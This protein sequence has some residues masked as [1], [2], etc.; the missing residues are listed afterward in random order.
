MNA[1]MLKLGAKTL[2]RK[3]GFFLKRHAPQILVGLGVGGFVGTAVATGTA[4][5]KAKDI[6][7]ERD[8]KLE[9]ATPQEARA[10]KRQ[11]AG[12]LAKTF[13]PPVTLGCASAALIF[14]GHGMMGRRAAAALTAAYGAQEKAHKLY[15]NVR[16]QLG[17]ETADRLSQGLPIDK[18]DISE[19]L[20][21]Q[22]EEEK[23][24][25]AE[26]VKVLAKP[27]GRETEM[28]EWLFSSETCGP[29]HG[30]GKWR[31]D[32]EYIIAVL[33]DALNFAQDRLTAYGYCLINDILIDYFGADGCTYG[34]DH[35]W[36]IDPVTGE[37]PTIRF[38][39][40]Y[41]LP[42]VIHCDASNHMVYADMDENRMLAA[43]FLEAHGNTI[44]LRFNADADPIT[45]N[46]D[47]IRRIRNSKRQ[48]VDRTQRLVT[49]QR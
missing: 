10:I 17:Q 38:G 45:E 42:Q 31:D 25:Q 9:T 12:K 44:W 20:K 43:T 5:V 32:P 4:A 11:T 15:E 2:V 39:G 16:Q 46:I 26:G 8:K 22:G 35:G 30:S 19:K 1:M 13:A 6:L 33:K 41:M 7:D 47:V 29:I 23:K 24:N 49:V 48:V 3:T 40:D 18:L 37:I 14:G 27:D 28:F 34:A 36:C 21:I